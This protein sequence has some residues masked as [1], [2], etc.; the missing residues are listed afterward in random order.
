MSDSPRK[1]PRPDPATKPTLPRSR[2]EITPESLFKSLWKERLE[3]AKVL[4]LKGMQDTTPERAAQ[5]ANQLFRSVIFA[6][7]P[8]ANQSDRPSKPNKPR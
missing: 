1:G 3:F 8:E 7:V 2:E 5:E 4:M 6:G